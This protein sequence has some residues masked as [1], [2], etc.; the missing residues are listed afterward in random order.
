[1]NGR[2]RG[3]FSSAGTCICPNCGYST[4]KLLG[5]PCRSKTCPE[6]GTILVR[7]V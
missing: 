4:P 5:E 1:M 3:R 7:E 6:C 2:F